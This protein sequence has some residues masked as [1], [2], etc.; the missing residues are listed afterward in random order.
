[1]VKM[2]TGKTFRHLKRA[3]S[4]CLCLALLCGAALAD[5][6]TDLSTEG[7]DCLYYKCTLPDGR[8]VFAGCRSTPGRYLDSRAVLLCLDTDGTVSW[9]YTNP[10]EGHCFYGDTA[11]T[12]DGNIAVCLEENQSDTEIVLFS[13]DGQPAGRSIPMNYLV[14]YFL[15]SSGVLTQSVMFNDPDPYTVM[16]DWDGN[17]LFRFSGYLPL[18]PDRIVEEEDGMVMIG[19]EKN[20]YDDHAAR[21]VKMDWQGNILWDTVIPFRTKNPDMALLR[22]GVRMAGDDGYLARY[23]ELGTGAAEDDYE[24]FNALVRFSPAG[25]ILWMKEEF[26]NRYP[27]FCFWDMIGYRDRYVLQYVKYEE[28]LTRYL[29]LDADGNELGTTEVRFSA[30]NCRQAA[31]GKRIT[32]QAGGMFILGDSL[33]ADFMA[34]K[35]DPDIGREINSE[36]VLLVK[37]PEL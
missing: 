23:S 1:M 10:K 22:Q 6:M 30:E 2:R 32:P 33:Y 34:E 27:D 8:A 11:V 36:D 17:E 24:R 31:E 13:A 15:L 14:N 29:W 21:I 28:N 26:E 25:R 19:W 4:L 7:Q 16:I 20:D 3:L 37:V 18:Y 12:K 5:Q 35:E 9:E